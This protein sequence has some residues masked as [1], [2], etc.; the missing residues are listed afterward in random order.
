VNYCI[1]AITSDNVNYSAEPHSNYNN[2]LYPDAATAASAMLTHFDNIKSLGFNAIRVIGLNA[3]N[4]PTNL[5]DYNAKCSYAIRPTGVVGYLPL[6][7]TSNK[8]T[9]YGL[10]QSVLDRAA[11]KGLQVIL[12]TGNYS[13]ILPAYQSNYISY[14]SD[15]GTVSSINTHTALMAYDL[16]NEPDEHHEVIWTKAD[17]CALSSSMYNAI[18]TTDPNHLIT[19]NTYPSSVNSWD[20]GILSI[21]F[22]SFHY[23][24]W[25]DRTNYTDVQ[26]MMYWTK[27]NVKDRPWIVGETGIS[28]E[29][30]TQDLCVSSTMGVV[31]ELKQDNYAIASLGWSRGAGASGYSWWQYHDVYWGSRQE[32]HLGLYSHCDR[33][34]PI[35]AEFNKNFLNQSLYP[36]NNILQPSPADSIYYHIPPSGF[37]PNTEYVMTGYTKDAAGNPISDAMIEGWTKNWVYFQTFSK[38][39]GYFELWS[40]DSIT[41]LN[42]SNVKTEMVDGSA[43]GWRFLY[44]GSSCTPYYCCILPHDIVLNDFSCSSSIGG[45]LKQKSPALQAR[46]TAPTDIKLYPNP[47]G[48]DLSIEAPSDDYTVT[49]HNLVGQ[50]I[51]E[52]KFTGISYR[53]RLDN[54]DAGIYLVKI[55]NSA[56]TVSK[57]IKIIKQ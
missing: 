32:D 13:I 41:S 29:D 44:A 26:T 24:P 48:G 28:A 19:I 20:P 3:M 55:S 22:Y 38:S 35:T 51:K 36:C 39:N 6:T 43:F 17:V 53:S 27:Q 5:S 49:V 7:T 9:Y 18:K 52:Y 34:K 11:S 33:A 2:G 31:S 42:V 12:C 10:I 45:Y 21:D 23:Y 56:N 25:G 4:D 50:L 8:T 54:V 14:L 1:D 46:Q 37:G 15:L 30:S 16:Y 40:S 47:T 57:T